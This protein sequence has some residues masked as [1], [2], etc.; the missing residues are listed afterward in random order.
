MKFTSSA[1]ILSVL[2]ASTQAWELTVHTNNGG[3][4]TSHGTVNSGCVNYDFASKSSILS[5]TQPNY[6]QGAIFFKKKTD[7]ANFDTNSD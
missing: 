2:A 1:I 7:Q 5:T 4:I 6:L 3:H